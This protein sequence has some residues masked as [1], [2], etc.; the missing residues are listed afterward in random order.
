MEFK[1][2]FKPN[3]LKI[4]YS[5]LAGLF[6]VLLLIFSGQGY[7]APSHLYYN[8]AENEILT[9]PIYQCNKFLGGG[10]YCATP[11]QNMLYKSLE[12]LFIFI[13]IFIIVYLI[14]SFVSRK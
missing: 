11:L 6:I 8:C 13:P 5:G 14:L 7:C 3:K 2:I 10:G 1:E 4:I 9:M 12:F